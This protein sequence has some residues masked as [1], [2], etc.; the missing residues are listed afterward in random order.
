[1]TKKVS[2]FQK[3]IACFLTAIVAAYPLARLNPNFYPSNISE[4]F[5]HFF[6]GL[7]FGCLL[8][9]PF[10]WSY[11]ENKTNKNSQEIL[12][13]LNSFLAF[14]LSFHFTKWG[15]LKILRIHMTTSLG[16]MEMPMTMVSGEKQLSH[17]FGQSYPMVCVLGIAEIAGAIFI[18]FRRTRLLG[19]VI[20]LVM[21]GNIIVIDV[22]YEVY[23]PLREAI[24][25]FLG[26][27]YLLFQDKEK[28]FDFF[29]QAS[30]NLPNFN[31]KN[32]TLKIALKLMALIIP[33]VILAPMYK[34]Q[35]RPGLTGKYNITKMLV[36]GKAQEID[37]Q[38]ES[39]F[40]KVYFDLGDF[41]IFTNNSF[42]KRQMGHFE[43]NETTREFETT[44]TYPEGVKDKF[45]GKVTK[46]DKNNRMKLSGI[47]GKDTLN[48]ELEKIE[49]KNFNRTY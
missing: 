36:N 34:K 5:L 35:Y 3:T 43:I 2:V 32:Y 27:L 47:M 17:F 18:L 33:V 48:L 23:N 7:L 15:L 19:A 44:W 16:L 46:L 28:V 24:V 6:P 26:A 45:K 20:L 9:F 21:A 29:F 4:Q 22:L 39:T 31:F 42:K 14:A 40:S 11:I 49:I 25:L 38:N 41:F 12:G 1:M 10:L 37:Q 13:L 8:L 30:S